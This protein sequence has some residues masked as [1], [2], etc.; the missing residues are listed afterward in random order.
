MA[1]KVI[2]PRRVLKIGKNPRMKRF[3]MRSA[4]TR[5]R[6]WGGGL[7]KNTCFVLRFEKITVIL[8]QNCKREKVT[9]EK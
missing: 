2:A 9:I 1:I 7:R 6:S 8:Q 4:S 5:G 3:V